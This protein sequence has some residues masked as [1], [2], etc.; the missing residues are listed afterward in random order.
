MTVK[1]E[2]QGANPK[3]IHVVPT[4]LRRTSIAKVIMPFNSRIM[5]VLVLDPETNAYKIFPGNNENVLEIDVSPLKGTLLVKVL[6]KEGNVYY[7]KI[8]AL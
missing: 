4:M 2:R 3:E 7:K 1:V 6:D 8:I 5:E